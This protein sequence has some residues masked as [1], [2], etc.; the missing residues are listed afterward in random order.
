MKKIAISFIVL[1]VA[2]QAYCQ[3]IK[4]QF[5]KIDTAAGHGYEVKFIGAKSQGLFFER[6][7]TWKSAK[8]TLQNN[9]GWTIPT[10]V[11]AKTIASL[12]YTLMKNK[13]IQM[14]GNDWQGTYGWYW[15]LNNQAGDTS[16]INQIFGAI[17]KGWITGHFG[18]DQEFDPEPIATKNIPLKMILIRSY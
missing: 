17:G 13:N 2:L 7:L 8:D 14:G 9:A 12:L 3:N 11:Q 1:T 5:I 10:V 6:P 16:N 4:Q 15:A 18:I